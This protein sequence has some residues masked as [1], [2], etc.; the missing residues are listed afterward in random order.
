MTTHSTRH[1]QKLRRDEI[2]AE[3][4]RG[5]VL[6]QPIGAVEQH[7]PHLPLDTDI[8]AVSAVC[9]RAAGLLDDPPAL[10][11]PGIPWGLS[12][13][14]LPF[15]GTLSLS[16]ATIL[17]LIDDIGASAAAHGF[18]RMVV[19][20]GH[21]G[22]AGIVAVAA[23]NLA[24]AGIRAV[25]LS[26]WDVL[27]GDLVALTPRD[28]G[29][30]GHA[31]QTETSVQLA[32]QPERVAMDLAVPGLGADLAAATAGEFWG[33][34]YAPPDPAREAPEGVYGDPSAADAATGAEVLRR[35]SERLA[36]FVRAFAAG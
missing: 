13:Y 19:V 8:A 4:G 22:N 25:S 35:A 9:E 3:A 12:P 1:W 17:A 26:W 16:P 29:H 30:I 28:G 31:G 2:A 14:W 33:V 27:R 11:L 18:R 36:A 24:R 10:V 32:L 6:L 15:A 5:A 34:G 7:G 20:N 23:T 21:G